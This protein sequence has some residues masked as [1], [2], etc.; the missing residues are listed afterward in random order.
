M[1]AIIG[2]VVVVVLVPVG[3][4]V[5]RAVQPVAPRTQVERWATSVS[6][7]DYAT[8]Q[9]SMRDTSAFF[10][11]LWLDE[12]DRYA[13]AGLMRP[14]RVAVEQ[15]RG[16]SVFYCV[17]FGAPVSSH[18]DVSVDDDGMVTVL[19]PYGNGRCPGSQPSNPQP[20][21]DTDV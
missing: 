21:G 5:L 4:V 17:E 13:E 12:T 7:G 8:A 11:M 1:K 19:G 6:L 16:R 9:K 14:A 10:H 20:A 18:L 2:I 15:P 3:Y